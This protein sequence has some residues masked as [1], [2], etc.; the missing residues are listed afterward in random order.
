MFG[1]ENT[2]VLS[3]T[4]PIMFSRST[5]GDHLK[6]KLRWRPTKPSN[7]DQFLLFHCFGEVKKKK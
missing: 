2:N 3:I 1:V 7:P 4:N 6:L 5:S